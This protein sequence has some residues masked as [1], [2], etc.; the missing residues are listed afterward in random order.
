MSPLSRDISVLI[1]FSQVLV[2]ISRTFFLLSPLCTPISTL[3]PVFLFGGNSCFPSNHILHLSHSLAIRGTCLSGALAREPALFF[4]LECAQCPTSSPKTAAFPLAWALW[5]LFTRRP[6]RV[7]RSLE[8]PL[9]SLPVSCRHHAY[10][11]WLCG[12][13]YIRATRPLHFSVTRS[14]STL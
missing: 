6:G 3:R 8:R 1:C 5:S 14:T 11:L 4:N 12:S 10:S 13:S 2:F 7:R 9:Q